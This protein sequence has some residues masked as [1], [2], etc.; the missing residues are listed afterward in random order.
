MYV[1]ASSKKAHACFM[2]GFLAPL[3]LDS[4]M[5]G[6]DMN[7]E[8]HDNLMWAAQPLLKNMPPSDLALPRNITRSNMERM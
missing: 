2:Q 8:D 3:S 4:L 6:K 7:S 5:A 1:F